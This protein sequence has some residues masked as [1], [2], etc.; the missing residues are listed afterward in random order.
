MKNSLT[1]DWE[2]TTAKD[3]A[4]QVPMPTYVQIMHMPDKIL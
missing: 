1:Q 2:W 4:M 3:R